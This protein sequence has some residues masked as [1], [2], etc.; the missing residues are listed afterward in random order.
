[1]RSRRLPS[2]AVWSHVS[3][4]PNPRRGAG[5]SQATRRFNACG[6]LGSTSIPRARAARRLLGDVAAT[7]RRRTQRQGSACS[8]RPRGA[9]ITGISAVPCEPTGRAQSCR[10]PALGA[11]RPRGAGWAARHL[12]GSTHPRRSLVSPRR[13]HARWKA[14]YA[15]SCSGFCSLAGSSPVRTRRNNS[16]PC[17]RQRPSCPRSHDSACSSAGGGDEEGGGVGGSGSGVTATTVGGA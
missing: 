13:W 7:A 5:H 9:N 4:N 2:R 11:G 6:S 1:M 3:R 14:A 12:W 8:V 17:A 10:T 16:A 15:R